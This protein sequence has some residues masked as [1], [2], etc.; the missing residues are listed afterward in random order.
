MADN[1]LMLVGAHHDDNEL[2]AGTIARHRQA[3]WR[4]VSVVMTD[5]RWV[6]GA[7]DDGN[8][9][10]RDSESRAAAELLGTEPV[11]LRL[12]EGCLRA[13][14]E[15]CRAVVGAMRE[16]RPQVVATHP[17]RDYHAD[18]MATSQAVEDAVYHCGSGDYDAPGAPC[19]GPRLYYSDAWAMPFEPDVYVDVS[20][21]ADLKQEALAC[22]TSQLAPEGPT[23]G[24]MIDIELTRARY[25]GFECGCE[26]AE[27][28]RFVPRP[29]AVRTA[30]L[31]T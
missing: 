22:H 23:R 9:A 3:G 5:G 14:E 21:Y 7:V 19:P 18:H 4:V 15:A 12:H 25:R 1:T 13:D 24:D 2:M 11:F 26:Y 30:E 31:L 8:V 16:Y 6:R 28:F 29:G 17:R 20:A 27:A 10:T